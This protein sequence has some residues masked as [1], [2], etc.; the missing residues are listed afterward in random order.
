MGRVFRAHDDLTGDGVA[1]KTID[2]PSVE[3]RRRLEREARTLSR[4]RHESIV[5]FLDAGAA[6]DE[7]YFTMEHVE[8][9]PLDRLVRG[10]SP[11]PAAVRWIIAVAARIASALAYVHDRGLLH[12]DVKPS[13]VMVM[14]GGRSPEEVFEDPDP[15]IKLLDFGLT[16]ERE[17]AAHSGGKRAGTPLYM[18]PECL[19]GDVAVDER[20]DVYSLGALLY[21]FLA[22]RPPF[23]TV[24]AALSRHAAAPPPSTANP[25]CPDALSAAV[26]SMIAP[27]P[28]RRPSSAAEVR[29]LFLSLLDPGRK[30]AALAPRLIA[31]SFV[32]R[33]AEL[34][35]V[36]RLLARAA[37]GEGGA[38]HIAGERGAGKTWLLERSG[39]QGEALADHGLVPLRASFR[40]DRGVHEGLRDIFG[41]LHA[42]IAAARG[43]AGAADAVGPRGRAFLQSLGIPAGPGGGARRGHEAPADGL[44]FARD[45]LLEGALD[46]FRAAARERPL[47]IALDDA[48]EA[49][50]LEARVIER[51]E[52]ALPALPAAIVLAHSLEPRRWLDETAAE[53]RVEAAVLGGMSDRD[54]KDLAESMLR[55]A[56][57]ASADLVALLAR[58]SD[59]RPLAAARAL[60]ALW[61]RGAVRREGSEWTPAPEAP[62]DCASSE[63]AWAER[64]SGLE[65][66]EREAF[67]AA[68]VL[69]GPFDEDLIERVIGGQEIRLTLASLVRR[70]LLGEGHGDFWPPPDADEACRAA[71]I[72]PGVVAA[73]HARA[74]EALLERHGSAPGRL[75]EVARH[76]HA[77]G[78]IDEAGRAY[79]SAARHAAATYANRRGIDA[80]S[81]ALEAS[82]APGDRRRIA[83]E[84]GDLHAR[85]G[86]HGS[87]L[88]R[89]REALALAEAAPEAGGAE[90]SA[91][92]DKVGR[93][94]QRQGDFAPALDAFAR[95]LEAAGRDTAGRA[96]GLF[97]IG[98]IHLERGDTAG[99]RLHLEESL[100]L[101]EG[102]EDFRQMAAVQSG[103]GVIE[104]QEDRLDLAVARFEEALGNAERAGS[105]IDVATTLNN[106]GNIQRARGE[107]EK[108]IEALRRSIEARE[109]VGDRQGLAVCLNN[110]ARVH[111]QRGELA[112]ARRSTE[113]ALAA[114]EEIGDKKGVLIARSNLG[115]ILH[116]QGELGR[117]RDVLSGNLD[118]AGKLRS[119]RLLEATLSNMAALHLDL[120]E[121]E[122]SAENARRSLGTM[123][124]DRPTEV[125]AQA[126]RVLAAAAL[127][128]EDFEGAEDAIRE[129]FGV[130]AELGIEGKLPALVAAKVRW[131]LER[132]EAEKALAAGKPYLARLDRGVERLGAAILRLEIGRAYRERGPDWA[133][134]TEK[135]ILGALEAF[136][137][138]G[139]PQNA[140]SARL[141]LAIYWRLLG[142]EAEAEKE[143][144]MAA[145]TFRAIGAGRRLEEIA[146]I[147]G[148][149]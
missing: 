55:P 23:P 27:E 9:M 109:R 78:R 33:A 85:I 52:R 38:I 49:D 8:G 54:V 120:G 36:R 121:Y 119:P 144:A 87:A 3:D 137:A 50:D 104:K 25:H 15:A 4:L 97:R 16:R 26:L 28:R 58:R 2:A 94:L 76:L 68:L 7:V 77:A 116:L 24:A 43:A 32:G 149:A 102:L 79:L 80:Y 138:M 74:A 118:L 95:S 45:R 40:R 146:A 72:P 142:E 115:E 82:T 14:T 75:L 90:V 21:H 96:R 22:A 30:A 108:A 107:E 1:L 42:I 56:G 148:A 89:Y 64:L 88:D 39:I 13:N 57:E 66:A 126:L 147:G 92:L 51:L 125:R 61:Q 91:L 105:L 65:P 131:H 81:R 98:Q 130:A 129:A 145:A 5:R 111:L 19:R 59:G 60:Q 71:A 100:K 117:A 6:G 110:I 140:A 31:P 11:G 17:A 63:S 134:Q 101:Y 12:G 35:L 143:L 132:G 133:D 20:S 93:V 106:I 139:S 73:L 53:G 67:A 44:P 10:E 18:S 41:G 47:L 112:T 113:E 141:E 124:E 99:A 86:E 136:E 127:R 34:D 70:G 48:G 62:M 83:E 84:L 123:P 135:H 114:F 46:V 69:G 128:L 103:L 122:A 29:E 37:S